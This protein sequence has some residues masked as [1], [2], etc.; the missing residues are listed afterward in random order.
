MVKHKLFNQVS[1]FAI[2]ASALFA[3]VVSSALI[4]LK[5]LSSSDNN[6][7]R[8]NVYE[9]TDDKI[10]AY[11]KPFKIGHIVKFKTYNGTVTLERVL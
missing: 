5:C 8:G 4:K 11:F 6:Y 2:N 7:I 10:D 9:I 1:S 3:R